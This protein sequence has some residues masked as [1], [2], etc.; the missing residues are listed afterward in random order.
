VR[1]AP[2]GG[3]LLAVAFVV[4]ASDATGAHAAT[5]PAGV[6]AGGFKKKKPVAAEPTP[7]RVEVAFSR[8]N[9]LAKPYA[10]A[11]VV[12]FVFKGD[13][14]PKTAE[15]ADGDYVKVR[16]D[17][18]AEGWIDASA[19]RSSTKPLTA[20]ATDDPGPAR[21]A[22]VVEKEEAHALPPPPPPAG[23]D[24][25]IFLTV[26][27]EPEPEPE[28]VA[29]PAPVPPPAPV[30]APAARRDDKPAAA[31]A[32]AARRDDKTAAAPAA[33]A[34]RRDD[35]PAAAT[36]PAGRRDDKTAAAPPARRDDRT[37][38][39]A[40]RPVARAAPED[41]GPDA[42]DA[43]AAIEL[44]GDGL[45]GAGD[46]AGAGDDGGAAEPG[47]RDAP[48]VAADAGGSPPARLIVDA[49]AGYAMLFEHYTSD[50]VGPTGGYKVR[51]AHAVLEL[52]ATLRVNRHFLL[53]GRYALGYA[54]AADL[55]WS[56]GSPL[57]VGLAAHRL[58]VGAAFRLPLYKPL[59][60]AAAARAGFMA[61]RYEMAA[62]APD[63]LLLSTTYVGVAAGVQVEAARLWR[64][65]GA[66]LSA[67]L[68][69]PGFVAQTPYGSG[70]SAAALGARAALSLTY[71]F[72]PRVSFSAGWDLT[73]LHTKFSGG[74]SR[75][76]GT[77]A[78]ARNTDAL[79]AFE[80][81]AR[82]SL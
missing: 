61:T 41:D 80:L 21:A 2:P 16:A 77:N 82:F 78:W 35:K 68:L 30:A 81:G 64:G 25:S 47:A 37:V 79:H 11:R 26:L 75:H 58:D 27:P 9:L 4:M 40:A 24:G 39:A 49:R 48:V 57:H 15:S 46:G 1:R 34:A 38:R 12:A 19:V 17:A 63:S 60:L 5:L 42:E 22:P 31:P 51:L 67:D 73:W 53:E 7:P 69:V 33:P 28:P 66:A 56:D 45:P 44:P 43:A 36:A 3:V 13:V 50:A 74:G 23:T 72:S 70:T 54:P 6:F 71:V 29:A 59:R 10:D 55:T 18:G 65:L 52:A 76:G 8:A 62:A 32:P 20:G 14:L